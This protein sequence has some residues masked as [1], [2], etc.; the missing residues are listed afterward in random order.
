MREIVLK[1]R[2]FLHDL[3]NPLAIGYG[4]CK[5]ILSKLA[6]NPDSLTMDDIVKRLNKAVVAFEKVNVLIA[7]RREF[8]IA[9]EDG[10][11]NDEKAS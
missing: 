10:S 8:L 11:V 7:D 2:K 1:E 3:S 4:N 5:I 9:Q 6:K